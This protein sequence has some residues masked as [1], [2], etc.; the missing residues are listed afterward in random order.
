MAAQFGCP[1]CYGDDAEA[2]AA[3]LQAGG[4][5]TEYA[6]ID[7]SH[8]IVSLRRCTQCGQ[9]FVSIFTEFVDWSGGEDAQY[10]DVV[11]VTPAE[12][13]TVRAQG[14]RVDLRFLGELGEGRRRLSTDWPTGGS[15]RVRWRTGTFRVQ[16][17]R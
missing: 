5:K 12:A 17:G 1:Q 14:E 4:L 15:K 9:M 13:E 10:R 2:A 3:Y 7:D 6:L 16:E 8:F 11:P